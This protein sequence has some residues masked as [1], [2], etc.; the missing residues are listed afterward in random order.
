MSRHN[1]LT[2][3]GGATSGLVAIRLGNIAKVVAAVRAHGP[4]P[5][6]DLALLTGLA[7]PTITAVVTRLLVDGVLLEV[8]SRSSGV[9]GGRPGRLLAFNPGCMCVAFA[10]VLPGLVEAHVANADGSVLASELRNVEGSTEELFAHLSDLVRDLVPRAASG[11]LGAVSVV[12]PGDL[13]EAE[14][15]CDFS[16]FGWDQVPVVSMLNDEL[17]VPVLMISPP[18]ATAITCVADGLCPLGRGLVVF[19]DVGVSASIVED[20]DA[21]APSLGGGELGHCTMPGSTRQ[22]IC[23]R[24]GCLGATASGGAIARELTRRGLGEHSGLTLRE[25]AELHQ[26][27]VDE[28]LDEAAQVLGTGISWLLN[29]VGSRPVIIGGTPYA[30]GA[31]SFLAGVRAAIEERVPRRLAEQLTVVGCPPDATRAG[32]I[33]AA[34]QLL[35]Q[36]LWPG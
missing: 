27:V 28:I 1:A 23:G 25:L 36:H 7:R 3:D 35:P 14:G 20:W 29:T 13:D 34:L 26:P 11:P 16:P 2:G 31:D 18:R 24:V 12:L 32:A 5:R 21:I 30:A 8:G 19:I 4:T 9:R 17:S 33:H 6:G 22:C 10:R 15:T